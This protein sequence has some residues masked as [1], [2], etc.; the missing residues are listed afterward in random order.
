MHNLI[1]YYYLRV[2][3]LKY[4]VVLMVMTDVGKY[5]IAI[6]KKIHIFFWGIHGYIEDEVAH[7]NSLFRSIWVKAFS[8]SFIY[9]NNTKLNYTHTHTHSTR[10]FYA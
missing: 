6:S 5:A 9:L 4:L 8:Y 7:F 1:S 2:H 10:I 3:K